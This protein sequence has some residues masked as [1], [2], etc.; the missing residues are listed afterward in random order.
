[1]TG[2]ILIVDGV[3]TNRIVLRV[4]LSSAYYEVLQAGSGADALLSVRLQ[5]PDLI[6]AAADLPDM[7]GEVLCQQIRAL[8]VAPDTPVIL[9]HPAPDRLQ[10]MRALAAGA[11]DMLSRP[12]DE[13]V[14]LARLRSLL[15]ARHAEDELRLRDDTRRA[16]G[17]AEPPAELHCPARVAVVPVQADVSVKAVVSTLRAR[18]PDRFEICSPDEALRLAGGAPEVFVIV[19]TGSVAGAGLSLLT[20][21]RASP[22]YRQSAIV[23]VTR[24]ECRHEAASALDLGANDLLADGFD[25]EELI[26]R[27]PKQIARKRTADRLRSNMRDGLRAAVTDPLTGLYNRR[28]VLPHLTRV[29]DRA[30]EKARSYALLLLDLDHFKTINDAHGHAVGDAVLVEAAR[31]MSA[32]LRPSDLVARIGGEE[33]LVVMPDTSENTALLAAERLRSVISKTPFTV[34]GLPEGG[35]QVTASIG[36]ALPRRTRAEPPEILLDRADRALYVAKNSGRNQVALA[37]GDCALLAAD[38]VGPP[39]RAAAAG[40]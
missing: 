39:P 2:R 7:T 24:A 11:D 18:L 20:Q 10:R 22:P 15:R 6:I 3:P 31:R 5:R 19:D 21:L 36:V 38:P 14:L 23:Y 13:L 12:V 37:G 16:L 4:R 29:A 9:I 27:L 30:I 1:M 40:P 35:R 33:F 17:L 8:Q 28:Y 32:N 25:A 34:P 26:L